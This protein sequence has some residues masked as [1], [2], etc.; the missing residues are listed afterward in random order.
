MHL[1]AAL[2]QWRLRIVIGH[3]LVDPGHEALDVGVDAGQVL[4]PTADAPGHEPD[5]GLPPVHGQRK[6]P[7]AV[8]LAGIPPAILVA[9]AQE[10]LEDIKL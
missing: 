1:R 7:A 8:A 2:L 10:D 9:G 5:Q 6:R 4:P 3:D